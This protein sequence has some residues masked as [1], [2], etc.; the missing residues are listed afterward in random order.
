M[1]VM[2]DGCKI[3]LT[4]LGIRTIVYLGKRRAMIGRMFFVR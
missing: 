1:Y 3:D 4:V 2:G